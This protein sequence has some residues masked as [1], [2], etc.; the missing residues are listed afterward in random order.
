MGNAFGDGT[1]NA[2][3]VWDGQRLRRL[4]RATP[5]AFETGN[6]FGVWDGQRLRRL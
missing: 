6:A 4:R 5:S 1:G 2:F 3:G